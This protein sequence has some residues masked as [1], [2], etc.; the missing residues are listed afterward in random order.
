MPEMTLDEIGNEVRESQKPATDLSA[1]KLEGD[2]V[3]ELARG[4]TAAELL[5]MV[6]GMQSALRTSEEARRQALALAETAA[7]RGSNASA[8]APAPPREEPKEMGDDELKQLMLDNPLE[9]VRII[10]RQTEARVTRNL[11]GRLGMLSSS[12]IDSQRQQA[13]QRHKEEFDILGKE[14]DAFV[15][16]LP[17]KEV[18]SQPGAWDDLVSYVRGR[19]ENFEK[20]LQHKMKSYNPAPTL[21]GSRAGERDHATPNLRTSNGGDQRSTSSFSGKLTPEKMDD[22]MK[23]IA[24]NLGQTPEQYCRFYNAGAQNG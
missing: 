21:E 23:E 13:Q 10:T 22:T 24:R 7:Q 9:A 6:E 17:N 5:Q 20:V 3:P 2:N 16:Q 1:I 19:P 4:K 12:S 14:I 18:L 11:E 15:N 8:P